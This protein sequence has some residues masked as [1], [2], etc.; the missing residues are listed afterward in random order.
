MTLSVQRLRCWFVGSSNFKDRKWGRVMLK[1]LS[2]LEAHEL[3]QTGRVGRLGCI[4]EG[5]PYITPVSYDFDD[6]SIYIHSLVGMKITALRSNPRACLQVDQVEGELSWR[7][8][9][10]FGTFEEIKDPMQ[11]R[12]VLSRLFKKFPMLTPIESAIAEDSHSPEVVVFRIKI[13][14]ITGV[15]E[16]WV[17]EPNNI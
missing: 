15:G 2:N 13:E 4:H 1:M 12:D 9:I 3:L 11:R 16:N 7:S 10:A 14:K 17:A 8:V 5:Y 6:D